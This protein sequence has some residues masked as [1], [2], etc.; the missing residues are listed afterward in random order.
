MTLI[1]TVVLS[2]WFGVNGTAMA[3]VLGAV[4]EVVWLLACLRSHF[5]QRPRVLWPARERLALLLAYGGGLFAARLVDVSLAGAVGLL[6]GMVSGAAAFVGMLLAMG[7]V[8]S[9]D[10]N[11]LA[12]LSGAMARHRERGQGRAGRASEA[13][14]TAQGSSL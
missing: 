7:A 14:G 2:L 5:S 11:R 9:R 6:V 1:L 12:S 3:V 4:L 13:T 10:R 8:N